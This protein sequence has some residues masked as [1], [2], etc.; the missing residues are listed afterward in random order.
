MKKP[1]EI[2]LFRTLRAK[3]LEARETGK[4][5]FPYDVANELGIP[6]KRAAFIFEKWT[7]RLYDYGVNVC[8]GWLTEEALASEASLFGKVE[9]CRE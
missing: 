3:T 6:M 5:A 8:F 7:P 9:Q 4:T 1:D 2:L